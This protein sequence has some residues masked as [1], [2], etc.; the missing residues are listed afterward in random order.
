MTDPQNECV[1]I[2]LVMTLGEW[3]SLLL[4][5]GP[6]DAYPAWPVAAAIRKAICGFEAVHEGTVEYES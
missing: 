2:R 5:I 3:K 4:K 6:E 1:S